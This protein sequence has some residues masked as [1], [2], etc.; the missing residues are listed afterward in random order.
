ME[1]CFYCGMVYHPMDV[2]LSSLGRGSDRRYI[3]SIRLVGQGAQT[4]VV[5][6]E[7]CKRKAEADGYAFRRDLTPTR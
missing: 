2:Y 6:H 3:C 7:E 5:P 1:K 4:K